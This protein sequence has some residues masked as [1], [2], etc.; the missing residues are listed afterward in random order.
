MSILVDAVGWLGMLVLLGAYALL[1]TGRWRATG[2]M[3]QLAN[4]V[5][6]VLLAVNTAYHHAWP[7]AALNLVW[8]VIGTIGIRKA[9]QENRRNAA[10]PQESD[11][12]AAQIS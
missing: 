2:G 6:G 9:A 1:T 12:R 7:S 10:L 8:F 5:G 3:Y 11:P 4:V